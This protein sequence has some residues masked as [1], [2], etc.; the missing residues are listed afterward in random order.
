MQIV[1]LGMHRS[2]TSALCGLLNLAGVY[3]GHEGEF[4]QANE[5]NPKGFWERK[6]VRHLNDK[7]LYALG[8]DW[9]EIS[10]LEKANLTAEI[11]SSFQAEAK[12][13]VDKMQE[14]TPTGVIGL[15]EPRF[16]LLM[17]FWSSVLCPERFYILL[18]RNPE[19]IAI[20]LKTRNNIPVE[21]A[22]YLTE[23]YLGN[24]ISAV[25]MESCHIVSFAQMIS[26]P[27]SVL[28]AV[29]DS[30]EKSTGIRLKSPKRKDVESF[31]SSRL[32]R[33][34]SKGKPYSASDQLLNWNKAL[35][36]GNL[37][38]LKSFHQ[39]VPGHV[40][41][42]E[43]ANRFSEFIKVDVRFRRLEKDYF[44][45]KE[46][47]T[48][49]HKLEQVVLQRDA[50]VA[51]LEQVAL[52]RDAQVADLEQVTLQRDAQVADLEKVAL[53]R[54]AQVADLEKGALRRD[55][56]VADLE[57]VALQRDAQVADLEQVALQRD[58]QVADLEQAAQQRD[59]QVADLEQAALQRDAQVA[60]LEKAALQ[61]DAQVA[62]LEKAAQ[63]RD[64]QVADLEK[65]AL[66]RDAQ[67]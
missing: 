58:A 5:E 36:K 50:Q 28:K 4:I 7:I 32:Y 16:C 8:C 41:S 49:K 14:V 6:D 64:A 67:V 31:I 52:Q 66:Q 19:E 60:D 61:R 44:S 43:H 51:D 34:K 39:K 23:K 55:A 59:A 20:S 2:G 13:I 29:I 42:Y 12:S 63:Q 37:P 56:Q 27:N 9:S 18:Q 24:A 54:D 46:K 47:L 33:S 48:N 21:V 45:V 26:N 15:K 57:Q 3:F 10:Q 11:Q 35:S 53:Q 40:L 1:V 65:V 22:N 30:F 62:D 25:Q 38:E 17:D